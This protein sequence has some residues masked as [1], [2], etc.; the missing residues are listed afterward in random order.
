MTKTENKLIF[1]GHPIKMDDQQFEKDL[2]Y[3]D[4]ASY[5]EVNDI[6][7]I[8]PTYHPDLETK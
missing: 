1:I 6:K 3:I 8:V 7:E 2:A 5:Q 4:E